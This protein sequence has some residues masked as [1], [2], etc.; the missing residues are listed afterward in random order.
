MGRLAVVVGGVYGGRQRKKLILNIIDNLMPLEDISPAA[1][2]Y[3]LTERNYT[4]TLR[5]YANLENGETLEAK[6]VCM[7]GGAED[8]SVSLNENSDGADVYV[9][10]PFGK[11]NQYSRCEFIVK[12]AG[13]YKILL[14][15]RNA[16]GEEIAQQA[17]ELYKTFAFSGGIQ[18]LPRNGRRGIVFG[19]ACRQT[20]TERK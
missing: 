3:Q 14:T 7:S 11:S 2:E 17:V 10:T 5:V 13:V 20:E 6:L 1:Y 18:S 4:N 16:D 19:A 12:K 15:K 8:Y 9:I